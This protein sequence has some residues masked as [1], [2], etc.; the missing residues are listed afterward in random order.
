MR[1]W[2]TV[3]VVGLAAACVKDTAP[4]PSATSPAVKQAMNPSRIKRIARDMPSGYEVTSVSD[5]AAPPTTWGLG[6]G[7]TA[8]P[9][10]CAALADPA[11]GHTQSAQGVSGS[12]AGGIV[13]AIVT[14]LPAARLDPAVVTGC[15]R[16][17][18]TNGRARS[19]VRL[20]DP[21]HIDGAATVAMA[22][23]TTTSAE[24]GR[25]IE[26]HA[27]TVIAYL[28]DYYAFTTLV[29]DPGSAPSALPP[30]FA[31][32]LLVKTVSALRG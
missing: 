28:G 16:W 11:A 25:R 23:D 9:A 31:A 13:Y 2:I 3:L 15:P 6:I 4:T 5:V 7:W 10:Q 20:V 30:Q 17:T 21:P 18:V 27:E 1:L 19:D 8:D 32:D 12:G 24:G 22:S 26:S 29:T 14:P